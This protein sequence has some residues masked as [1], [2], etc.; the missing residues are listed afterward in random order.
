MRPGRRV[1]EQTLKIA[2]GDEIAVKGSKIP[3]ERPRLRVPYIAYC[4]AT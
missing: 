3:F 2:A 1:D 4:S